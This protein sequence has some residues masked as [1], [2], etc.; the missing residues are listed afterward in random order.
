M[1]ATRALA[2]NLS[3]FI[4]NPI[5]ALIFAAALLVFI[6]GVVE[7]MWGLSKDGKN[8]PEGKQHMLWGLI[9][10]FLMVGAYAILKVIANTLNVSLPS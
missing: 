6:W 2:N 7:Y 5:L 3:K 8:S 4:I 9:G 10:M 1:D